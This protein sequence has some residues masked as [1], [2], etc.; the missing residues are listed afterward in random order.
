MQIARKL[1]ILPAA[2][3]L[4]AIGYSG[5]AVAHTLKVVDGSYVELNTLVEDLKT[6]DIVFIGELHGEHG[7]QEAQ[8]QIVRALHDAGVDV[9]IAMEMMRKEYQTV[10]DEWVAGSLSIAEMYS[11]YKKNWGM[12]PRYRPIFKYARQ[13]GIPMVGLNIPRDITGQVAREG[14]A[15]LTESDLERLPP[16]QC[17]IDPRYEDFIRRA[18]GMHFDRDKAFSNFCEAQLLWDKVMAVHLLEYKEKNPEKTVVV[19]AG[20]GHSWKYGIPAQVEAN[21]DYE[22]LVLMPEIDGRLARD[23][24]TTEEVDYLL[25]GVEQGPLH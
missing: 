6:V 16:V 1:M 9:A 22:Y 23:T 12:W 11:V 4:F 8:L 15:S 18:M 20:S 24:A 2:L 25:M 17:S 10:L 19:L 5:S 14:F 3:L 21:S 7:H 13:K